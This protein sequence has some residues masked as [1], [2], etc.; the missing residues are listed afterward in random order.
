M[1]AH[2]LRHATYSARPDVPRADV[3]LEHTAERR[4]PSLAAPLLLL[5][6]RDPDHVDMKAKDGYKRRH[7]RISVMIWDDSIQKHEDKS[8]KR[9]TDKGRYLA[10]EVNCNIQVAPEIRS[11]IHNHSLGCYELHTIRLCRDIRGVSREHRPWKEFS[12]FG[13]ARLTGDAT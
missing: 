5:L 13:Y 3:L 10:L 8:Q 2:R 1:L 9:K 6:L 7:V 12:C 11:P 4:V